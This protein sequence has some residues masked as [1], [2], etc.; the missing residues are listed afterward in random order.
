MDCNL[1]NADINACAVKAFK[2]YKRTGW[3]TMKSNIDEASIVISD[4]TVK[5]GLKSGE[6]Y[7][8]Y[9]DSAMPFNGSGVTVEV[10]ANH[11]YK[12]FNP[13]VKFPLKPFNPKYANI[14]SALAKGSELVVILEQEEK[15]TDDT[16]RYVVFGLQGGLMCTTPTFEM[17]NDSVWE[18]ELVENRADNPALFLYDTDLAGTTALK[19]LLT[20]YEYISGLSLASGTVTPQAANLKTLYTTSVSYLVLPNGTIQSSIEGVIS[21]DW[22]G[23][24]GQVILIVPKNAGSLY[25]SDGST[26][27]KFVGDFNLKTA[28][29]TIKLQY[30]PYVTSVNSEGS[31]N[32]YIDNSSSIDTLDAPLAHN[33]YAENSG[34][35]AAGVKLVI[36]NA[37]SLY[38]S[39]VEDGI[40]DMT[41]TT[42]IYDADISSI[43]ADS[44]SAL[45]SEMVSTG[46]WT[47]TYE[48][49]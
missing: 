18:I 47:I 39:G 27:S 21:Y 36:D 26:A 16:S 32:V 15:G 25:F 7:E 31:E 35:T 23:D 1:I 2:G 46:G 20:D 5:F 3:F 14:V 24:A 22:E 44:Y 4:A 8:I 45:V 19:T 11:G 49:L 30:C 17:A 13:T 37:Y 48:S 41:G 42:A 38:L 10:S 33:I 6:F 40:I 9:D 28:I 43:H 34:L 29:E 12:F